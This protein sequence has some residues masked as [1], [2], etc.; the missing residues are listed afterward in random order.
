MDPSQFADPNTE[1]FRVFI[2]KP[3]IDLERG[4]KILI[5]GKWRGRL[6]H[7]LVFAGRSIETLGEKADPENVHTFSNSLRRAP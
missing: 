5:K 6:Q 1:D 7:T 3:N 4:D 2:K